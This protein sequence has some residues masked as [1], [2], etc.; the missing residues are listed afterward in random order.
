MVGYSLNIFFYK[1][2]F[3]EAIA[4]L[5]TLGEESYKDSTLI[6][7][8]LRDNLTLWTSDVQVIALSLSHRHTYTHLKTMFIGILTH[9]IDKCL[10]VCDVGC[11]AGPVRRAIEGGVTRV[12]PSLLPEEVGFECHLLMLIKVCN[13]KWEVIHGMMLYS[14]PDKIS[15]FGSDLDRWLFQLVSFIY[16]TVVIP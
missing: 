15:K 2:A 1:K 8:L 11:Y 3:E 4:E 9:W 14:T 12:G 5:D 7:Q 10:T 6:M 13:L 16:F